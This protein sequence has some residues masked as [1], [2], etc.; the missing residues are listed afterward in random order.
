MTDNK[1][2][3]IRKQPQLRFPPLKIRQF[4]VMSRPLEE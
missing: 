2:W 3:G 4:F 1:S